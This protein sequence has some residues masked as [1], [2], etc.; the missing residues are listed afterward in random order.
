MLWHGWF[1]VQFL[2]EA[3]DF[4]FSRIVQTSSGGHPTSFSMDNRVLFPGV[5]WVGH[6][7]AY[8]PP[9]AVKVKNEFSYTSTPGKCLRG[10]YRT[11]VF[12]P[13][14]PHFRLSCWSVQLLICYAT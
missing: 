11:T 5:K 12:F 8:L 10:T 1:E 9:S 14:P 7:V 6:E 2:R 13:C 3:S 4:L